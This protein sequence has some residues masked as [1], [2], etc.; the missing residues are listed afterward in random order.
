MKKSLSLLSAVLCLAA[1]QEKE[2]SPEYQSDN[3]TL[4]VSME[5]IDAT[6]TS[7]D[8]YNNVLWSEGDQIVA[9]MKTT[10]GARYQIKEQYVGT[11]TGGFSKVVDSGSGDDLESG[12]EIDHNVVIYP[13]S[14]Q[15]WC[16]KYD[17][18]TPAKS[19][20]LNVVLPET[21]GYAENSFANGSF[22]M[23]AVS[24]SNQLTFKN[25]C[26]GLKLQFKGVDKIKS[27]KLEGLAGELLSG[28]SSV[29][30]Y[31]D[32]STP[33]ISMASSASASV[34]LDCG[35]GVQLNES[36]P[37]TF[38][39]AVPPTEFKSGMK[40]TVTDT[41]GF[42][43]TLTNTSAN[44]IKRSSLLSFPAITYKQEGVLELPEGA[45]TSYEVTAEGGTVE[46]PIV[47]NQDYEVVIPEGA[48]D[49]ISVAE[50]RAL[51]EEVIILSVVPNSY[52]YARSADVYI[53]DIEGTVL[54]TIA[55]S[56]AAASGNIDDSNFNAD[57]YLR[58]VSNSY[59]QGSG[60]SFDYDMY[61]YSSYIYN[62]AFAAA[63]KVEYKFQLASVPESACYLSVVERGDSTY[64]IY[65]NKNGLYVHD[66]SFTW[67]TLGVDPT[68]VIV[69]SFDDTDMTVN[70]KTF[71]LDSI[72]LG[73]YIFSGYY[74][75][76]DDGVYSKYYSFQDGAK[77]FYAKG[78]DADGK[79]TYLGGPAISVGPS[80][81]DEACWKSVYYYNSK[82]S[83]KY[84]Y[85]Y[86]TENQEYTPYGFGN[87]LGPEEEITVTDLSASGTANCYIISEAGTYKFTPNKGSS[88]ESVGA[89]AS[90]EVLWETF[91]TDVTPNVGDLV[92][93]VKYADGAISFDTPSAF[94]EGNAV[95][96]AKDASG[97]ILWSWHIWLTDQPQG[98]VYYNNAGTMMDRNLGA[99]S[100]TPGDVGA[101]GLLYQWG[102]KDPFLGSS[103]VSTSTVA[104]ST[105]N[106]PAAVYSNSYNGTIGYAVANPMTFIAY[107]SYNDD[108][109]YTGTN[110]TDNTRWSVGSG[111]SVYDPCPSGWRVPDY[112]VWSEIVD[113]S[114]ITPEY[115]STN[116]GFNFSGFFGSAST[117]WYPASGYRHTDGGKL[118]SA[119]TYGYYWSSSPNS[120]LAY[121]LRFSK[122]GI[123]DPSIYEY[124]TTGRSVRCIKE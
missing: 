77:L 74:Y 20:K 122:N 46:I 103:S 114:D 1:C 60:G 71:T 8:E 67:E 65:F 64:E 112:S 53:T 44:T 31:T 4:Y 12:Q 41:D 62:S 39:I 118:Y 115:D 75:D 84:D 102:R 100:A 81:S 34:T 5:S 37:T 121:S 16:M 104:V 56:Q 91:G 45:L 92:K 3:N 7:M 101:L 17:N 70:G 52:T 49:W 26:G 116:G 111:K 76:R 66:T 18:N 57:L 48:G 63:S 14:D 85:A 97:N 42:S 82:I 80:G 58:Y 29:V 28:K 61:Y 107:N 50:T 25:I 79:L 30:V 99:T 86:Y 124:R 95:I 54:Q 109:Y 11:T 69:L 27:I 110:T 9:F 22:P 6:R 123:L 119:G 87:L 32:G 59:Y 21:Q 106:W 88:S 120:Y 83:T 98:Q 23:A 55:I 73:G 90:A 38:I 94:K 35:D 108:W 36:T 68:D 40:I 105:G 47:T 72:N 96:A 78:W 89:V 117:I 93:N 19:Y 113:S 10:L 15:I 2:L 13:Y 33:V 51:R 24:S 43:K